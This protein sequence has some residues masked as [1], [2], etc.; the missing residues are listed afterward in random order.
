MEKYTTFDHI[1]KKDISSF[2][3]LENE[4]LT[5]IYHSAQNVP[6]SIESFGITYP[7]PNFRIRRTDATYFILEYFNYVNSVVTTDEILYYHYINT[8]SLSTTYKAD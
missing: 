1:Q 7:N 4:V 5:Y 3:G 8:V 6:L 2:A